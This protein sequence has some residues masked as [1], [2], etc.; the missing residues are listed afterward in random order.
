VKNLANRIS[1]DD[2][3]KNNNNEGREGCKIRLSF[4][5]WKG[6]FARVKWVFLF[7]FFFLFKTQ[8]FARVFFEIHL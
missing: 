4:I 5:D 7:F 8:A 6:G 1:G 3:R 2:L